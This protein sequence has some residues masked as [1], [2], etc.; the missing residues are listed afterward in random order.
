MSGRPS[1]WQEFKDFALKG[2]VV[3]LAVGVIIGTSF[4]S[5]T[6]SLVK[7]IIMPPLGIIVSDVD[8]SHHFINLSKTSYATLA[9]AQAAGVPTINYGLFLN[10]VI[11]FLVIALVVFIVVRQFNRVRR[12]EQGEGSETRTCPYCQMSIASTATRCPHCTSQLSK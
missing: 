2:S 4:A 8:F 6:N 7:D 11:N 10:A 12:A 3:D 5:I 1:F 9:E